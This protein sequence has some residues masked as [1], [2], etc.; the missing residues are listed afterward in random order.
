MA[1]VSAH[2]GA[3]TTRRVPAELTSV[4]LDARGDERGL[5]VSWHQAAGVVVLSLWR[6]NVCVASFRLDIDEVP[7]LIA[8]LREGL[9]VAFHDQR[10]PRPGP[11]TRSA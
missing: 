5:K 10:D 4:F 2:D 3:M 11:V 8:M 7:D 1:A 6:D 9:D